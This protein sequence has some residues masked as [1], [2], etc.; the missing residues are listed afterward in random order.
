MTSRATCPELPA[1][2][3][4]ELDFGRTKADGVLILSGWVDWADGSTF[5]G[6]AQQGK[7]GL[8]RRTF[9]SGTSVA[10]GEPSSRT[11]ACPQGNRRRLPWTLR[12]SGCPTRARFGSLPICVCTGMRYFLAKTRPDS[13]IHLQDAAAAVRRPALP[14]LLAGGDSSRAKAAGAL[15]LCE[16]DADIH[17]GTPRP[18]STRDT[19]MSAR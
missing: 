16:S 9:R 14:G 8:C 6:V 5:L 17:C 15:Q 18:D 2:H 4:L 7:G 12:A 19:V 1:L 13:D 11:W 3:Y 10:R